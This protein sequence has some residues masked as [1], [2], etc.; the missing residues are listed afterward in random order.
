M[1]TTAICRGS[2]QKTR[3]VNSG[4]P[5]GGRRSLDD[6]WGNKF[7]AR[8]A[9]PQS[10]LPARPT[11]NCVAP[12]YQFRRRFSSAFQRGY[13]LIMMAVVIQQARSLKWP[14][15]PYASANDSETKAFGNH[16][17]CINHIELSLDVQNDILNGSMGSSENR[18]DLYCCFACGTPMDDFAL[19]RC[20]HG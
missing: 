13:Y 19:S 9:A 20:D 4:G 11:E 1:P 2:P 17:R 18:C 8:L 16:L 5:S 15:T 10:M 12:V 7:K 3:L 6:F 14:K